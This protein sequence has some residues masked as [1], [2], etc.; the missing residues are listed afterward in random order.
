M[1]S[2]RLPGRLADLPLQHAELM[3]EGEHLGAE[4]GV[5]ARAD[6]HEVCDEAD[7]LVREAEQHGDGSCPI[8]DPTIE[9]AM[10]PR[11]LRPPCPRAQFELTPMVLRHTP[12][13][14]NTPPESHPPPGGRGTL[15]VTKAA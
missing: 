2:P 13:S 10:A 4:L 15:R 9:R 11:A 1:R 6:E 3:A 12:R 8:G 5:G 14:Q 7:E